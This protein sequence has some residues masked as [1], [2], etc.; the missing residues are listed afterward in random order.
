MNEER[1]VDIIFLGFGNAF[2]T[3]PCKIFIDKLLK[4]ELD[5]QSVRLTENW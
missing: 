1:A 5:E 4:H 3:V 2:G